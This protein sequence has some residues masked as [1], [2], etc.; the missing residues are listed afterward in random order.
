MNPYQTI[1]AARPSVPPMPPIA[2]RHLREHLFEIATRSQTSLGD[3]N[4]TAPNTARGNAARL[5]ALALLGVVGVGGLAYS[6]S[7]GAETNV[8]APNAATTVPVTTGPPTTPNTVL[9]P[10]PPT[11]APTTTEVPE[12]G[13][14]ATPLLLPVGRQ[15]LDELTVVRRSLGGAS[16]LLRAPDLS[17]ISIHEADGI[18]PEPPAPPGTDEAGITIPV[19]QPQ[20]VGT[21]EV[22]HDGTIY[23]VAVPCGT[24]HVRD[25]D[26]S[27]PYRP[28]IVSLL[29]SIRLDRGTI[30]VA[31]PAGWGV[32]GAG[33]STDAFTFGLP[34][35]IAEREVTVSLT[36]Y[37]DGNL[38]IAGVGG[39]WSPI[40]FLGQ[41][42]WISRD[43]DDA[44]EIEVIGFVGTTAFRI[45]ARAVDV[46]D[47]EAVVT[48]LE[49]G[50]VDEWITR[51]GELPPATDPDIRICQAQPEFAV[52]SV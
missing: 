6:A 37:P 43:A 2:R 23:D 51:F 39:Q 33:P 42:A 15:P 41:P 45:G 52:T 14:E 49:P 40:T 35:D 24:L 50:D 12:P 22:I 36:Q 13:T 28:E 16:L 25:R 47:L 4:V 5:A 27:I 9:Q 29:S 7:R 10:P 19:V 26:G 46:A 8:A 32:I 44:T 17:T 48:G 20:V 30:N 11:I 18:Q 3:P 34:V 31:L 38:A 21:L 1:E